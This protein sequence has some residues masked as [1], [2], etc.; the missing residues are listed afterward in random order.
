MVSTPSAL[1]QKSPVAPDALPTK[2]H[3]TVHLIMAISKHVG[4]SYMFKYSFFLLFCHRNDGGNLATRDGG[5][6]RCI[7]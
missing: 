5:Q 4:Y 1:P 3:Y 2:T 6:W 7:P